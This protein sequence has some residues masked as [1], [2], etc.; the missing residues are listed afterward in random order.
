[1]FEQPTR[2][3]EAESP[4]EHLN[5]SYVHVDT[6]EEPSA[7]GHGGYQI[8]LSEETPAVDDFPAEVA[9]ADHTAPPGEINFFQTSELDNDGY[10]ASSEP[11]GISFVQESELG[12]ET[13]YQSEQLS[14]ADKL[15][16]IQDFTEADGPPKV[17]LGGVPA[18][19]V[20]TETIEDEV[21][22]PI[23]E[24]P[25]KDEAAK[26]KT[27]WADEVSP[28]TET[29]PALPEK[30][31]EE[32][33]TTQSSRHSRYQSQQQRGRVGGQRGKG[34]SWRGGEGRGI[35]RGG[36]RGGRGGERGASN[37]ERRG[38]WRGGERGR[39]RGGGN[40]LPPTAV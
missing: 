38:S 20:V 19:E 3:E 23:L 7:N 32:E 18:P 13:P 9:T 6:A 5:G 25:P 30:K 10:P 35:G 34:D 22:T 14:A 2:G 29:A 17:N 12:D 27:D 31:K 37:G 28:T 16:P 4:E 39:A 33:W 11:Q 40:S 8:P 1:M 26:F 21:A 15:P 36:Y 24:T